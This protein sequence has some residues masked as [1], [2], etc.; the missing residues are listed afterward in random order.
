MIIPDLFSPQNVAFFLPK[1]GFFLCTFGFFFITT[2]RKS[3]TPQKE[4]HLSLADEDI[5]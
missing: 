3:P 1:K 5:H 4:K 2:M